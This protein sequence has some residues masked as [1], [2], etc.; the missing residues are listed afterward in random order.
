MRK[1]MY[2]VSQLASAIEG[3]TYCQQCSEMEAMAE[4]DKSEVPAKLDEAIKMLG[5]I[6]VQMAQEE[7]SELTETDEDDMT[8]A[9]KMAKAASLMEEVSNTLVKAGSRHNKADMDTIQAIHDHAVNLGAMQADTEKEYKEN[10]SDNKK[11]EVKD[12]SATTEKMAKSDPEPDPEEKGA[13]ESSKI[14]KVLESLSERL[15]KIEAQPAALS[16]AKPRV[17]AFGKEDDKVVKSAVA[18]DDPREMMKSIYA[19]GGKLLSKSD[20]SNY[21]ATA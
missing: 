11:N 4:D 14:L 3:L 8:D 19:T 7:V 20:L 13:V 18:S 5:A 1:G 6:L 2:G 17:S 9:E 10:K 12:K 15:S 16:S 21:G